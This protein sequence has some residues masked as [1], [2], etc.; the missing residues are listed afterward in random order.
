MC[1][2]NSS[3]TMWNDNNELEAF[4]LTQTVYMADDKLAD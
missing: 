3:E 1:Q 2:P 4:Q